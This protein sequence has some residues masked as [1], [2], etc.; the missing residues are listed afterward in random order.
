MVESQ[1]MSS[2][3][4]PCDLPEFDSGWFGIGSGTRGPDSDLNRGFLHRNWLSAI[5]HDY[6]LDP[7]GQYSDLNDVRSNWNGSRRAGMGIIP[8]GMMAV[9][10]GMTAI[11]TRTVYIP[12]MA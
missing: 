5:L 2:N 9:Q 11:P 7:N 10:H 8:A 3:S 12:V 6:F 4:G 1:E